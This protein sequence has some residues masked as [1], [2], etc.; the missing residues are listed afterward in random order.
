MC[1]WRLQAHLEV[2]A[3][4][5]E[6][7]KALGSLRGRPRSQKAVVAGGRPPAFVTAQRQPGL[8][9]AAMTL[10]LLLIS[11]PTPPPHRLRLFSG[12]RSEA[13]MHSSCSGPEQ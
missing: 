11:P 8:K 2:P 13:P 6:I 7:L 3:A 10:C 9:A 4:P 12:T 1:G 5:R